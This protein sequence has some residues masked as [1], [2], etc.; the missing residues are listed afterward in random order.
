MLYLALVPDLV[1]A[2]PCPPWLVPRCYPEPVLCVYRAMVVL[3][4]L[5]MPLADI[6][7]AAL[8][9]VYLLLLYRLPPPL[10]CVTPAI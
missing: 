1:P 5:A 3:L 10:G 8:P 7:L 9:A 6:F 4:L 2:S